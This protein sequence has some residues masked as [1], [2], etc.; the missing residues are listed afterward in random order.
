MTYMIRHCIR[1]YKKN[2]RLVSRNQQTSVAA[3]G[4]IFPSPRS[5]RD[6]LL[7]YGRV[8]DALNAES[9]WTFAFRL[10]SS[11]QGDCIDHQVSLCLYHKRPNKSP[12]PWGLLSADLSKDLYDWKVEKKR[13][14]VRCIPGSKGNPEIRLLMSPLHS[15]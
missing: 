8:R 11:Q 12:G 2:M 1:A 15:Q 14:R 3:K 4:T 9:S 6:I 5:T 7:V 13:G 10:V